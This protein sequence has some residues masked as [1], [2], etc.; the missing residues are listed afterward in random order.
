MGLPEGDVTAPA[1][2]PVA[3]IRPSQ[4]LDNLGMVWKE[5]LGEKVY[6]FGWRAQVFVY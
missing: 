4:I 6:L 5:L 2:A 3:D 1:N